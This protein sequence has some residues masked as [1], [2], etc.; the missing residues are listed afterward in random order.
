MKNALL[1]YGHFIAL[2]DESFF[3]LKIIGSQLNSFLDD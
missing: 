3:P 1:F 2:C